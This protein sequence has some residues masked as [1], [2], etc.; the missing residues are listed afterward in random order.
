MIP[1]D[2]AARL[3]LLTEAS[4][5]D[6]EPP[7]TGL[8]RGRELQARLPELAPGERFVATIDRQLPDGTFRAIVAGR[9]Y[10]LALNQSAKSGDTLELIVT[11]ST[12]K[13][14]FAQLAEPLLA[15]NEGA[16]PAL[17]ATGRLIGFLLTGQPTPQAATLA[18]GKPIIAAPPANDAAATLAPALRQT[19]SQSG[20]F[21]ESHQL[22]WISGKLDTASLLQEPQGEL[23]RAPATPSANPTDAATIARH[24]PPMRTTG[25]FATTAAPQD[26]TSAVQDADTAASPN[27][28]AAAGARAAAVPERLAP[29]VYQQLDAMA[30]QNYVWQGQVWPGQ[31]MEWEI[32]DPQRDDGSDADEPAAEWKT[33]LRLALPRLGGVE[34]RLI[35]TPAGVALRLTADDNAT[36]AALVNARAA[37]DSA[38]EAANVPLAGFV[39]ERRDGGT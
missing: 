3:R 7:L 28:P 21:Y 23:A 32:E 8:T 26:A 16:R 1:S 5:F 38:L 2:L 30:T 25:E 12:P 31:T 20:L 22:Q 13:A 15:G 11:D 18:G 33:T 4:L 35:L 27:L 39:A 37:L 24:A 9:D 34:A 36:V 17:S 29:V 10:T 6:S 19:L 14:V